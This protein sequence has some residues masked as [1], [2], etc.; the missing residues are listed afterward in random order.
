[1]KLGNEAIRVTKCRE[2]A[3]GSKTINVTG[4]ESVR[5]LKS[6]LQRTLENAL[7]TESL[8]AVNIKYNDTVFFYKFKYALHDFHIDYA[9]EAAKTI[10]NDVFHERDNAVKYDTKVKVN[11]KIDIFKSSI[12]RV[13][14]KLNGISDLDNSEDLNDGSAEYDTKKQNGVNK[15]SSS[16]KNS[17]STMRNVVKSVSDAMTY[18]SESENKE[19][20][21]KG[22]QDTE[23]PE[24]KSLDLDTYINDSNKDKSI[25]IKPFKETLYTKEVENFNNDVFT[26]V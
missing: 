24:E 7:I 11:Q 6:K 18:D 1:M 3:P 9:A 15:V 19:D 5:K 14:D 13:S 10:V 12:S 23:S 25:E 2:A 22:L 16:L 4:S 8:D 17:L 26:P 21:S 20:D